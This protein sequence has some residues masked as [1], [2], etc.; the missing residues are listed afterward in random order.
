MQGFLSKEPGYK[1]QTRSYAFREITVGVLGEKWTS[2]VGLLRVNGYIYI[3]IYI[4]IYKNLLKFAALVTFARAN[5]VGRTRATQRRAILLCLISNQS[6][7]SNKL[8]S[9][10]YLI[11]SFANASEKI[12][13]YSHLLSS[14]SI[15]ITSPFCRLV[16]W[17]EKRSFTYNF[18]SQVVMNLPSL[19]EEFW[20]CVKKT[21]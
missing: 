17:Q 21:K 4:Y 15:I 19:C 7:I 12:I 6:E 9:L 11:L 18:I 3:Y 2:T 8:I 20:G 1:F 10:S 5:W 14:F 16:D 13:N